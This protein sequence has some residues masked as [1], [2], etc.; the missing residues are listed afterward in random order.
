MIKGEADAYV[1]VTLIKKWDICA[2]NAIIESVGG[3]MTTLENNPIDYS[4]SGSVKNENGLLA[5]TKL[6]KVYLEKLKP[7]ADAVKK[8]PKSKHKQKRE[9]RSGRKKI[10]KNNR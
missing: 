9:I 3:K 6:H 8:E 10:S 5:T 7:A 2:G 4:A 1:H